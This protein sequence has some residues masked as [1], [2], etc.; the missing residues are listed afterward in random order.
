MLSRGEARRFYDRF[1]ARQDRQA[2][3]EDAAVD[4]LVENGSFESARS[5]VEFGCG[6]GRFA[7]RLLRDHLDARAEYRGF[8]QS[9]TMVDLARARVGEFGSRAEIVQTDGSVELDLAAGCCDRFVSNYVIEIL[10]PED[11]A[12]LIAEAYRLLVP[13]GLLGLITVTHGCSLVSQAVM[14][15]WHA[16]HNLRPRSVGGCEPIVARE[17]LAEDRWVVEHGRVLSRWGI[18]SEIL[19]A[20]R[21]EAS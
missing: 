17:L 20:R 9:V 8:D 5:V 18:A 6:T 7:E 3:Y 16:V 12:A 13:G 14:G 15:I 11:R 21:R 10:A 19:V 1:G 2:F 4:V